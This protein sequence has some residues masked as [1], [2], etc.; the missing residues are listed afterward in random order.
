[1]FGHFKEG[2]GFRAD[3]E[4]NAWRSH[5]AMFSELARG[6]LTSE[7][8][9]QNSWLNYGPPA[10]HNKTASPAD[11]IYAP[12]KVGL[13]PAW[14]V[15]EGRE[16]SHRVKALDWNKDYDESKHPRDEQ[17]RW[18]DAYGDDMG[19]MALG[20]E[21]RFTTASTKK[22]DALRDEMGIV[23]DDI[24]PEQQQALS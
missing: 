16:D 21:D 1:Y 12:Q 9:G 19:S 23:E 3:G 6:A 15:N 17:G 7:T 10:E 11:T 5:A 24:P 2:V 20:G 18:T 4:E 13:M 22:V 8:R 14:T